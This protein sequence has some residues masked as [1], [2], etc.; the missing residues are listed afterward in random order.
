MLLPTY[1]EEA[2][3]HRLGHGMVAGVD[4][5]G[6]GPLAGPVVAAAVV[7]PRRLPASP[8]LPLV[9]DSK[10]L[11]PGQRERVLPHIQRVARSTGVG[12]VT[13]EDIDELGIVAATRKAMSLALE[14]LSPPPVYLLVD[15]MSLSWR[16]VPCK[17]IVKGDA[18]CLS[19]AAASIVAKVTRDRVM[20]AQES[21]YAGYGF[22]RHKGYPTSAHL[23]ALRRLGPCAIHRRSFAPVRE[24]LTS[25]KREA[26]A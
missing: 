26:H 7:F 3:L 16:D 14:S 24:M 12:L 13:A 2:R 20:E 17:A 11:S 23:E 25:A 10:T 4:E 5:V 18:T 15:A 1:R 9:R 22:A 21:L 8:W 6:R 19:I